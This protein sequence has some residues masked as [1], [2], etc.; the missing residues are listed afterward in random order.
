MGIARMLC[1]VVAAAIFILL[2]QSTS[3]AQSPSLLLIRGATIIDGLSGKK[4]P[5]P[6]DPKEPGG[7]GPELK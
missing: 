2:G 6:Y 1:G 5:P 4:A 7:F 3:Q